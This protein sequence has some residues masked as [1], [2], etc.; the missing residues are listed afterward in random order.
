MRQAF[1]TVLR[2]A[3]PTLLVLLATI[4]T[5][6]AQRRNGGERGG[7]GSRGNGW[8]FVAKKYD[9]NKDG[10]VSLSEYSRGE[11]AFKE[12]DI[13]SDGVL[14]EADWQGR[15]HRKPVEAAPSEGDVAPDFSLTSIKDPASTITLSDFAG[16]K[17]VA[18]LFGSCT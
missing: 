3:V 5:A 11:V 10:S 13:N 17:P 16:K 4:D 6:D 7:R 14:D 9:A 2:I 15:S 12:L 1:I 18:L 8:T